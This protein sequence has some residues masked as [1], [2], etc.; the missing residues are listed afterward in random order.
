MGKIKTIIVDDSP[1][2]RKLLQLMIAELAPDIDIIGEAEDV[3]KAIQL[4]KTLKPQLVFLDIEMP[5]K[6]GLQLVEEISKTTYQYDVIFTT[7]YNQYAL[8]AF[9]LSAV[10]YLLKP[11]NEEH[12]LEAIEKI[13]QKQ[14][15]L[16]QINLSTLEQNLD[17]AKDKILCV[18][19]LNGTEFL[20][21]NAIEYLKADGSYVNIYRNNEKPLLA[22]KNLKFFE[23][24]LLVNT[25][26]KRVH[27]SYIVNVDYIKNYQKNVLVMK[28]GTT[29]KVARERT[30]AFLQF[31]TNKK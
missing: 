14:K 7:A 9:R 2:A 27:R 26:F 19:V 30:K 18:Q 28:D 13:K 23:E 22:S 31:M 16:Q 25:N 10:D 5:G 1:K 4:I 29:I 17:P 20:Q 3:E 12:L 24:I 11:I 15:L 6:S 21:L 8:N